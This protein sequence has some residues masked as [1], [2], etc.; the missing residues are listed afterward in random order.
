MLSTKRSSELRLLGLA[1]RHGFEPR[2]T[3]PKAAVLPLDDRGS[4]CRPFRLSVYHPT[5]VASLAPRPVIASNSVPPARAPHTMTDIRRSIAGALEHVGP[6]PD[7]EYH[8]SPRL[9]P[10]HHTRPSRFEPTI[11]PYLAAALFHHDAVRPK[12]RNVHLR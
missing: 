3:A 8:C 5:T 2:F 10:T 12:F 1:P 6:R 11:L 9:P 7:F 4:Q